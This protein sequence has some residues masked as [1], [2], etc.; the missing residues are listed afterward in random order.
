MPVFTAEDN[1][2]TRLAHIKGRVEMMRIAFGPGSQPP[3]DPAAE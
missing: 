3:G 1:G 2:I